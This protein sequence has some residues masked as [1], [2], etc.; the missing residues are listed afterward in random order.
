MALDQDTRDQLL[1]TIRRF[2]SDRLRPLEERVAEEDEIPSEVVNEMRGL[3]LFGLTIPQ[4]HG[5]LGLSM[6][7][8]VLVGI[9]FGRTSPAFRSA[10][11]TNVGSSGRRPL[12]ATESATS[13][14]EW[15]GNGIE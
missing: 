7:E 11:G 13:T 6:E 1:E 14:G 15:C 8:E 5:G 9:E 4:E 12:V 10:F 3:G 2:V